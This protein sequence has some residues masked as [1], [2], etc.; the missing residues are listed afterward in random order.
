[1]VW[2]SI[3]DYFGVREWRKT[4]IADNSLFWNELFNFALT[5]L[6]NLDRA[7]HL[8]HQCLN[9]WCLKSWKKTAN[10]FYWDAPLGGL[11]LPNPQLSRGLETSPL[12]SLNMRPVEHGTCFMATLPWKRKLFSELKSQGSG[13]VVYF[14]SWK[15]EALEVIIVHAG[16]M[17]IVHACTT[18][19]VRACTTII[20]HACII[21][22]VHACTMVIV[23]VSCPTQIM[24]GEIGAKSHW[25]EGG[26]Q[27][28]QLRTRRTKTNKNDHLSDVQVGLRMVIW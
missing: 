7:V 23:R 8:K 19:I 24:V 10:L 13:S 22:L 4:F 6:P 20:V 26:P 27:A 9:F 5:S 14:R 1:M 18:V 15:L 16:A 21:I 3:Y 28:L 12:I 11:R 25:K 17:I 2:T